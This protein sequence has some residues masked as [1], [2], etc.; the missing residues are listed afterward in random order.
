M[1]CTQSSGLSSLWSHIIFNSLSSE[2]FVQ[3]GRS[4][5][6]ATITRKRGATDLKEETDTLPDA[7]VDQMDNLSGDMQ[8]MVML[9]NSNTDRK[10][11]G[12]QEAVDGLSTR[13]SANE[14]SLKTVQRRMDTMEARLDRE[15]MSAS[16]AASTPRRTPALNIAAHSTAYDIEMQKDLK[17]R[18]LIRIGLP[19]S[20][21]SAEIEPWLQEHVVTKFGGMEKAYACGSPT[22][23]VA[24]W[25]VD[26]DKAW[27]LMKGMRGRKFTF[28]G[29]QCWHN[30]ERG[31]TEILVSKRT[32]YLVKAV[33][34]YAV[35]SNHEAF[36]NVTAENVRTIVKG[37]WDNGLIEIMKAKG[38]S[39]E[40]FKKRRGSLD[41]FCRLSGSEESLIPVEQLNKWLKE[42]NEQEIGRGRETTAVEIDSE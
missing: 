19:S 32:S 9:I 16:T 25:F 10:V 42:A 35:Q 12:L 18:R 29:S 21:P 31:P 37:D 20:A 22:R 5:T 7:H 1:H 3:Y 33:S 4:V 14:T 13:V 17:K 34:E 11:A 23:K 26:N 27:D 39:I 8:T 24:V 30:F 2:D 38:G 6:T 41:R 40:L 15:E 36:K 28:K